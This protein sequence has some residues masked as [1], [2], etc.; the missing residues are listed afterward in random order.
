MAFVREKILETNKE[1][2]DSFN[3]YCYGEKIE[4]N[5]FTGWL[6]DKERGIYFIY[7]DGGRERSDVYALIWQGEIVIIDAESRGSMS[8]ETIKTQ[9]LI[10]NIK[11]S[12]KLADKKE[13]RINIIKEAFRA[14]YRR[15][16]LTYE[17]FPEPVFVDEERFHGK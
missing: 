14:E 2:Y 6:V 1:L 4:A 10:E 5:E 13:E 9:L 17:K 3:F 8:E 12:K 11:A 16:E 15:S 7:L